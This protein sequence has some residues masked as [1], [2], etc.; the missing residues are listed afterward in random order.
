MG[1]GGLRG[2][3]SR[4]RAKLTAGRKVDGKALEL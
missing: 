1:G 4:V 3:G 2:G